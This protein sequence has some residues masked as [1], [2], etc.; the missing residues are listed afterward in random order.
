ML[1]DDI[2]PYLRDLKAR[3]I[4][5]RAV[6]QALGVSEEHVSRTLKALGI[7][8]D[9]SIHAQEV[10]RKALVQA[11]YEHRASVAKTLPPRAAAKAA[12]CSV[13]TIYRWK[14]K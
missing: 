3:L 6:A 1:I 4:T 8:K 14:K 2:Q 9:P 13:R 5:N 11:R 12:G 10:A 7:A